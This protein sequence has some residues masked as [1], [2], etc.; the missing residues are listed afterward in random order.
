[1]KQKLLLLSVIT[2]LLASF[3]TRQPAYVTYATF[4]ATRDCYVGVRADVHSAWGTSYIGKGKT[5]QKEIPAGK[6]LEYGT[7]VAGV[8]GELTIFYKGSV[9]Q[10][11]RVY[12]P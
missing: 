10:G 9:G 6:R 5:W 4:I 7:A 12:V 8:P 3:D 1:M 2:L 11:D